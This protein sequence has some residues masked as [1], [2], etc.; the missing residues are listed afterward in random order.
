MMLK[1]F[2]V[3]GQK[4]NI[5]MVCNSAMRNTGF[6][7]GKSEFILCRLRQRDRGC[8]AKPIA[9]LYYI[10]QLLTL[11]AVP[12]VSDPLNYSEHMHKAVCFQHTPSPVSS[13][14]TSVIVIVEPWMLWF[15]YEV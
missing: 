12:S 8:S 4:Y 6:E 10:Y 14:P 9:G 11:L 13:K 15:P 2:F 3:R 5:I 1:A 7:G